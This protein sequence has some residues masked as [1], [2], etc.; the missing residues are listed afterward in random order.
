MSNKSNDKL[1]VFVE[2]I[3]KKNKLYLDRNSNFILFEKS[4]LPLEYINTLFI[5]EPNVFN[6]VSDDIPVV[7][8]DVT[9]I[10]KYRVEGRDLNIIFY[11]EDGKYKF[12][13]IKFSNRI[14]KLN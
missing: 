9:K 4:K 13:H 5:G 3:N 14:Y 10:I 8:R 2:Q 12:N 7:G 1:I 6:D 11:Y